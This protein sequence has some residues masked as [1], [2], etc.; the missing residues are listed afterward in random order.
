MS[1]IL[2]GKKLAQAFKENL[3]KDI[4]A[5]KPIVPRL[6]AIVVGDDPAS[7]IYVQSKKKACVALGMKSHIHTLP[8]N[9]K[10]ED[11][12]KLIQSLNHNKEVHGILLQLPLP[13]ALDKSLFLNALSPLKDVDCFHPINM[14]LL[15]EGK[16]FFIPCTPL[17][18][19]KLLQS[20]QESLEGK[21]AVVLGRSTL[22]GKPISLLLQEANCTVTMCHSKT[23]NIFEFTKQADIVVAAIGKPHFIKGEHIKKGAIVIDVGI[24][25]TKNLE[26]V[27]DVDFESAS[28]KAS[29]ITPVPGGVGPMTI[30]M[31]LHNTV[32]A[33]MLQKENKQ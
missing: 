4:E 9:T 30:A 1:P 15:L 27:G 22:V 2:D 33:A 29:W 3:K 19:L 31:L 24:N 23:K 5:L 14:G 8:H 32:R 12:L 6:D 26:I 20:T 11:L 25:H 28:K 21:H 10:S 18:I 13:Q 7:H 17:G 16:H